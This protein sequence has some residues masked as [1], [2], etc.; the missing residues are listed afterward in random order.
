MIILGILLCIVAIGFLCRLLFT[1][2]W[3][4][5][6]A[7]VGLAPFSSACWPR[8]LLSALASSCSEPFARSGR[9]SRLP[10]SSSRRSLLPAI[11]PRMASRN[12]SCLPRGG[13]SHSRLSAPLPSAS[14]PSCG[15]LEWR[16]TANPAGALFRL[17]VAARRRRTRRGERLRPASGSMGIAQRYAA[18]SS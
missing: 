1:L 3:P 4:S 13:K 11:M 2:A 10:L 6:R 9:S 7:Q 17:K 15:S 16:A 12:T 18:S 5:I 14:Q 8:D